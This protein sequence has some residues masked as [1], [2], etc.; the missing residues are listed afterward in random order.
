MPIS[1]KELAA[2][3]DD[4]FRR[5][6]E[7]GSSLLSELD[8]EAV[9]KSVV[10]AARE[11]TGA[12]YAALGV[13]DRERRELERFINVGIDEQ[14]QRQIGTLPRGRGVLGELIREPV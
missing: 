10:D 2:Q 3:G 8:L 11:L 14:T 4:R 6:F 12:R 9:L 5:L 7:V 13:L 1:E